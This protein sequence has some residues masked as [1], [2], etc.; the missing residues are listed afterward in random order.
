[1]ATNWGGQTT[2]GT[3]AMQQYNTGGWGNTAGWGQQYGGNTG[4]YNTGGYG[5][6]TGT[7]N[8]G[9]YGGG[10]TNQFGQ[11]QAQQWRNTGATGLSNIGGGAIGSGSGSKGGAAQYGQYGGGNTYGIQSA[12]ANQYNRDA[13]QQGQDWATQALAQQQ[14]QNTG[15]GY[16]GLGHQTY[17]QE[18]NIGQSSN[19]NNTG[20]QQG[21]IR[22]YYD[23]ATGQM[24]YAN[25]Q[26]GGGLTTGQGLQGVPRDGDVTSGEGAGLGQTQQQQ[27]GQTQQQVAGGAN[28]ALPLNMQQYTGM[29]A[30]QQGTMNN[31]LANN[32]Q[33]NQGQQNAYQYEQ[34]RAQSAM[35]FALQHGL[36]LEQFAA[37]NG[38]SQQQ[39]KMAQE[40]QA[41][42]QQ[43]TQAY[44][45][46]DYANM[47]YNQ[48]IGNRQMTL[49]EL[50]NKQAQ[51]QWGQQFVLN[52]GQQQHQQGMDVKGLQ[53]AQLKEEHDYYV[54]TGQ[55]DLAKKTQEQ[56]YN[57]QQGQ[58]GLATVANQRQ[59][60]QF[61]A[62]QANDM[63]KFGQNLDWQKNQFGQQ[64]GQQKYEFGQTMGQRQHEFTSQLDFE[65]EKNK[66]QYG[67][68]VDNFQLD[69]MVKTGELKLSQDKLGQQ[70]YEFGQQMDFEKQKNA[71][72]F[73]LAV[74]NFQLNKMIQ[75]GEL[76]LSKQK[77]GQQ[78]Y[79]F[80]QTFGE[81]QRQFNAAQQQQMAIEQARL[82]QAERAA[83]V[84]AVGRTLAPSAKW[85]RAT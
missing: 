59:N 47:Y 41:F 61:Y 44:Q 63:Q 37:Q 81:G 78:Q 56:Y 71:Q 22:D 67:L 72:Q 82:A 18:S 25:Q 38:I 54:Q 66:Q 46:M 9:N 11:Q 64:L 43:N 13:I 21:A 14:Q 60:E 31:W 42:N 45:N 50:Q 73:G 52:Q 10:F 79:E 83:N 15:A 80:G 40:A 1:M 53:L 68:A 19:N 35:Q 85:L 29:N 62:G 75:T 20:G 28:W 55:L 5:G 16:D 7:Y 34:D 65:K 84:A 58:L 23:S 6:N 17:A 36:N 51:Q 74:D 3:T 8:T 24:I 4:A 33:Y 69:K 26:S 30:Q 48:G 70:Q 27:Q 2:G 77:F 12:G 39:L 32:L 49:Q 76:D 57:I